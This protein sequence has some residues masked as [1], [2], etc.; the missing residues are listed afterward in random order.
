MIPDKIKLEILT[1]QRKVYE[2]EVSSARIPGA[3]GYFG[4]YPGH[5]PFLAT[6]AIG[7]IKVQSGKEIMYF[8]TS[9]GVA[10]V[11]PDSI[12]ILSETCESAAEID[13]ARAQSARKRAEERLHEGRKRWDVARA[14]VALLRAINRIKVASHL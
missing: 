11:L 4:V 14:Q 13:V 9:G 12:S 3:E 5:T 2:G 10:E 7:E 1:P 6:L 8:S